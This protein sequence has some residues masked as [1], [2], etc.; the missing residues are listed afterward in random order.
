[1]ISNRGAKVAF[2]KEYPYLCE[3][4]HGRHP[5]ETDKDMK[6]FKRFFPLLAVLLTLGLSGCQSIQK[7]KNITVTSWS[8]ESVVPTGLRSLKA[9]LAVGIENPAME[10]T[11]EDAEGILY[12]KGEEMVGY[13]VEPVTI[14]GKRAAVYPV[15]GSAWL[16]G[17]FS[18]L[19][20]LAIARNYDLEDFSTDI[21][22]RV[23]L[24]SGASKTFNL[25]NIPIKDLID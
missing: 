2:F 9:E 8:L 25:K 12:Y 23:R 6:A 11:V 10:F 15:F 19:N 18:V 24:K 21:R 3:L 16:L 7:I 1:M 5:A 13:T 17:N 4:Q 14:Q 22:A 20:V